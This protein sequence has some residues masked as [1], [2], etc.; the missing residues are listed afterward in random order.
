MIA[1]ID[2]ADGCLH[3]WNK[4]RAPQEAIDY[5]Q[6]SEGASIRDV[7]L[8]IRADEAC[9]RETN[10][11]LASID[12]DAELPEEDLKVINEDAKSDMFEERIKKWK[13]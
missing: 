13:N 1:D 5:Y 2:N 6:L 11:F 8:C 4:I 7:I 9:H 3:H 12:Q 10:H